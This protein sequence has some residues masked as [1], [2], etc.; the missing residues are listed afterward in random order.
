MVADGL[1][2]PQDG[3]GDITPHFSRE[4]VERLLNG[5]LRAATSVPATEIPTASCDLQTAA[6][7]LVCGAGELVRLILS[8]RLETVH[9]DAARRGYAGLRVDVEE[10]WPHLDGVGVE[11]F[12]REA[13]AKRLALTYAAIQVLVDR[14]DLIAVKSRSV[15]S[16][17][18]ALV[19]PAEAVDDFLK[20]YMPMRELSDLFGV[21]ANTMAA[22]LK[23]VGLEPLDLGADAAGRLHLRS[24]IRQGWPEILRETD[25]RLALQGKTLPAGISSCP[26][27]NV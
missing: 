12:T 13:L 14:Q 19:I 8:R 18:A 15:H 11:G 3:L 7:K 5:L 2:A 20:I 10:A 22:I 6:R 4:S 17:K 26:D 9:V 21:R 16:R 25:F 23:E 27:E 24:E 1:L